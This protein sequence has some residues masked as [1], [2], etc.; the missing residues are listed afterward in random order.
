MGIVESIILAVSLCA[1]CFAVSLCSGV[2][3]GEIRLRS[4][5]RVAL[6]FALIHISLLS[7]G[8]AFGNL[9]VGLVMKISNIIG[10][11]L[12]LYVGGE[13]LLEGIKSLRKPSS[14]E[15]RNLNGWRNVILS[16]IATS[17]DALAVGVSQSMAGVQWDDF[18][19]LFISLFIVT[20]LTVSAGICGGKKLGCRFGHWAEIGGGAVLVAIGFTILLG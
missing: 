1:D 16:G 5:L 6:G 7:A 15:V 2:T 4:V 20:V 17:I 8:W 19:T 10:F 3:L 13:M 18:R 14:R 9:F 12:L 11:L